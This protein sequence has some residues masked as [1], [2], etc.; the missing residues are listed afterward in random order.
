MVLDI[1]IYVILLIVL[2]VVAWVLYPH[3]VSIVGGMGANYNPSGIKLATDPWIPD[4]VFLTG[5]KTLQEL[6][7]TKKYMYSATTKPTTPIITPVGGSNP[8]IIIQWDEPGVQKFDYKQNRL[9]PFARA[10]LRRV[11][12]KTNITPLLELAKNPIF[13]K[14]ADAII[15]ESSLME[16]K[17]R[18]GY[19][20]TAT[21]AS[22]IRPDCRGFISSYVFAS[23]EPLLLL[24]KC[25]VDGDLVH[26][27][28]LVVPLGAKRKPAVRKQ[29][30]EMIYAFVA[31]HFKPFFEQT[32]KI[33]GYE[34]VKRPIAAI[35]G[36][37]HQVG[38]QPM[39]E[40]CRKLL[41]YPD[42]EDVNVY[43]VMFLL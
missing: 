23:P 3:V 37:M 43:D 12:N 27:N 16:D 38:F 11:F 14:S 41:N 20:Y 34:A 17:F 26:H 22:V 4:L 42:G 5:A 29:L 30:L 1:F 18:Y 40:R 24:Y 19:I 25:E 2:I 32:A 13:K 8:S 33:E 36:M 39:V 31:T 15:N 7:N 35:L 9:S 6:W 10:Q 21:L 28:K